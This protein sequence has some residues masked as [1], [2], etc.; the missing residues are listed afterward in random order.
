MKRRTKRRLVRSLLT[1]AVVALV[2]MLALL[3]KWR[4]PAADAS[5]AAQRAVDVAVQACQ[6]KLQPRLRGQVERWQ[7]LHWDSSP[8]G[9]NLTF[10]GD[11]DGKT[12]L[13]ACDAAP[14]GPTVA[15]IGSP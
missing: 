4:R 7:L 12:S 11:V 9:V 15:V 13:Y 8:Q 5:I 6:A 1:C 10:V 2:V 3:D 14:S